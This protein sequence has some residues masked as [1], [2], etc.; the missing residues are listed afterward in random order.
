MYFPK[1]HFT[2]DLDVNESWQQLKN[3]SA[4][5]FL[6]WNY[7]EITAVYGFMGWPTN[8]FTCRI[9]PYVLKPKL[10]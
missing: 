8:G 10:F 9:L 5:M 3:E 1:V 2:V 7:T 6:I 4:G